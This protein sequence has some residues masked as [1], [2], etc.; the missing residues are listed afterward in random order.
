MGRVNSDRNCKQG[1][2][3]TWFWPLAKSYG[4]VF[5]FQHFGF[6]PPWSAFLLHLLMILLL[7][8]LLFTSVKLIFNSVK[9]IIL[10]LLGR[11][12]SVN[13]NYDSKIDRLENMITK[14][15][16]WTIIYLQPWLTFANLFKQCDSIFFSF[17]CF[18]FYPQYCLQL[19]NCAKVY[20][21]L[22]KYPK[23]IRTVSI[24]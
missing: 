10:K 14:R 4:S 22:L 1:F 7:L 6:G 17:I 8:L 15:A 21:C 20:K 12:N 18:G 24:K 11:K 5:L 19:A 2:W 9:L 13:W 23:E 3:L 16:L